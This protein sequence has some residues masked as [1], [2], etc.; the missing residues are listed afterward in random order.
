MG[1]DPYET[2]LGIP[3]D[4]R[5]P[6]HYD[7]LGMAPYESDPATIDQ[8]ALRRM[9][10][11]RQYQIGPHSD[12]S[13]EILSELAR[14]R[15][16]LMDPDRRTDYDAKLRAR[17]EDLTVRSTAAEK[18]G[19]GAATLD[20]PDKS[21][22]DVFASL[23]LTL[24]A[25][26]R[27][28]SLDGDRSERPAGWKKAAVGGAKVAAHAALL[29]AFLLYFFGPPNLK[30]KVQDLL[31]VEPDRLAQQPKPSVPPAPKL[32]IPPKPAPPR[33]VAPQKTH[34]P[35]GGG[36]PE[37]PAVVTHSEKDKEGDDPAGPGQASNKSDPNT[38]KPDL[39]AVD[40][41][42]QRLKGFGLQRV[43][44]LYVLQGERDVL[45]KFGEVQTS[46][47]A[48]SSAFDRK[49]EI[50][51]RWARARQLD[52][53][54]NDLDLG[55]N[56]RNLE[57]ER[58]PGR[59]NNIQQNYYDG[60]R[61]ERDALREQ[62]INAENEVRRIRSQPTPP[63]VIQEL[64]AQIRRCRQRCDSMLGEARELINSTDASYERLA[65]ND[66]VKAALTELERKSKGKLKLG[67]TPEY[68]QI[69]RRIEQLEKSLNPPDP[70]SPAGERDKAGKSDKSNYRRDRKKG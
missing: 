33:I 55:I 70:M 23:A 6:T 68:R 32:N 24:Q 30:Q 7:L 51:F 43:G 35:G 3:P 48:Y 28:S 22:P 1:F 11:V 34:R 65:K 41:P 29:G 2:W 38:N 31:R 12:Q 21:A 5:S 66:D 36:E 46:F 40:S 10:K 27:P 58:G 9:S 39:A 17:G 52:Q 20:G 50:E 67:H 25:G 18:H 59:P 44:S 14:A 56:A 16:I 63:G 47:I 64:D 60:I 57:L 42:E 15:L 19:N 49:T 26:D 45:K 62:R 61:N 53:E 8:A 13:Q 37:T 4:R 54:I 69:V